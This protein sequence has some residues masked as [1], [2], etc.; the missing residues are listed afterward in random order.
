[1]SLSES[2]S[3]VQQLTQVL[4]GAVW[5]GDALAAAESLWLV[6][7][8]AKAEIVVSEA[9]QE[10]AAAEKPLNDDPPEPEP[11]PSNSTQEVM[12][13]SPIAE[14]VLPSGNAEDGPSIEESEDEDALL[15]SPSPP[16]AP[17]EPKQ[18]VGSGRDS[19]PIIVPS[20][21]ALRNAL[22]LS[23]ALRVLKR[24]IASMHQ[25]AI[26]EEATACR[27]IES[28]VVNQAFYGP[29]MVP[30]LE[31]W[32]EVDVV[33]EESKST[34]LWR[35]L[36]DEFRR[37]LEREGA[38]RNVRTWQL[39]ALSGGEALSGAGDVALDEG[40][41]RRWGLQAWGGQA[42]QCNRPKSLVDRRGRR[43]ILL[44]SDCVS[45]V[46]YG[47]EILPLLQAW[48]KQQPIALVQLLPENLWPRTALKAGMGVQVRRPQPGGDLEVVG[49]EWRDRAGDDGL[50]RNAVKLPVMALE[51]YL[52]KRW[53]RM[54]AG[55]GIRLRWGLCLMG[56]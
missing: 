3:L 54:L 40:L 20:A 51:P 9:F 35:D 41:Q 11:L 31:R 16:P 50:G 37:L 29:V 13:S 44:V 53:A 28:R 34:F 45:P 55:V 14:V 24:P 22:E 39:K 23:R 49:T 56:K 18:T 42:T 30:A 5:D 38:F 25:Q 4:L 36:I 43:L 27:M 2:P 15:P 47:G 52:M 21:P 8:I 17:P 1:M 6:D 46:W 32:L 48:G 12:P 33:V 7:Q 19:I 26:D 10:M